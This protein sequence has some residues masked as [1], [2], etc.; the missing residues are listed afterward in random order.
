MIEVYNI[1]DNKKSIIIGKLG[2][3]KHIGERG[4]LRN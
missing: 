4:V 3:G 1:V 2:A